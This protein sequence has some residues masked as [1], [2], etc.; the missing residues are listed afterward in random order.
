MASAAVAASSEVLCAEDETSRLSLSTRHAVDASRQRG[1]ATALPSNATNL[2]TVNGGR[3]RP[4][5]ASDD[6][7][8]VVT[9]EE[10]E[11]S[12]SS[13][14]ALP[15]EEEDDEDDEECVESRLEARVRATQQVANV[16]ELALLERASAARELA[17]R[18][19][20]AK[21]PEEWSLDEAEDSKRK[22][23]LEDWLSRCGRIFTNSEH[24]SKVEG[25]GSA[26][27]LTELIQQHGG[28]L[29]LRVLCRE[30]GEEISSSGPRDESER[31]AR[32]DIER[33]SLV[34]DALSSQTPIEGGRVGYDNVIDRLKIAGRRLVERA[35]AAE[36]RRVSDNDFVRLA[37]LALRAVNRTESGSLAL[38]ALQ[39]VL[40]R[41]NLVAV[42]DS[43]S[44]EPLRLQL[45]LCPA[46]VL[47]PPAWRFGLCAHVEG[48]TSYRL[49]NHDDF[50]HPVANARATCSNNIL[51]PLDALDHDR[52]AATAI[53]YDRANALVDLFFTPPLAAN[54]QRRRLA[55]PPH[56]DED[57]DMASYAVVDK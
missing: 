26:E 25:V 47:D 28:M 22:E 4:R 18:L 8:V 37:K 2:G 33:D 46:K 32:L 43:K 3:S 34:V 15:E 38:A 6:E 53:V 48:S 55:V 52:D 30:L 16:H 49:F 44:A 51:L 57:D 24:S 42:P 41:T 12:L 29:S 10:V 21:S 19:S 27:A 23:Q 17:R 9:V 45:S 54:Q 5:S 35:D 7:F 20:S 13:V 11:L 39:R 14:V 50:D 40:A 31:Q 56:F 1:L 36:W